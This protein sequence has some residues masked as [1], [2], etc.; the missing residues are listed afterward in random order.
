LPESNK[1]NEQSHQ[2][3]Q[4]KQ[5]EDKE[6]LSREL[7]EITEELETKLEARKK[8]MNQSNGLLTTKEKLVSRSEFHATI[9]GISMVGMGYIFP[10]PIGE[11]FVISL[12]LMLRTGL[13]SCRT[14]EHLPGHLGD[15]I[16][17]W[18]Y[19]AAFGFLTAMVFHYCTG[20]MLSEINFSQIVLAMLGGL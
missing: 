3:K 9:I 20:F 6:E 15:V 5:S 14:Q 11:L 12:L 1:N 18:A 8:Q 16:H 2:C 13:K 17:E 10:T 4:G 7:A 19:T